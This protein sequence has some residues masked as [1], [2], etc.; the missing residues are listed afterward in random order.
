MLGAR[1]RERPCEMFAERHEGLM[2]SAGH[3]EL[4]AWP[5]EKGHSAKLA[6]FPRGQAEPIS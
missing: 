6:K 3:Q 2:L 5:L 1:K 4:K